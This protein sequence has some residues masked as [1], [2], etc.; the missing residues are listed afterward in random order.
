M[1]RAFHVNAVT[2]APARFKKRPILNALVVAIVVGPFLYYLDTNSERVT[3]RDKKR[4]EK[5]LY[6]R[7]F[8]ETHLKIGDIIEIASTQ[9]THENP[10]IRLKA[11]QEL[12]RAAQVSELG[13]PP[14]INLLKDPDWKIRVSVVESLGRLHTHSDVVLQ[15]LI[16]TLASDSNGSVRFMAA[17]ALGSAGAENATKVVPGL[18]AA[19]DDSD[20]TVKVFS[21][22][23]LERFENNATQAISSLVKLFRHND[24]YVRV[25]AAAAVICI[26]QLPG[27]SITVLSDA[28]T[29]TDANQ[30]VHLMQ[31]LERLGPLAKPA[32]PFIKQRLDH[33]DPRVKSFMQQVIRKIESR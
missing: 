7:F 24:F 6:D 28:L 26:E 16:Q 14:L 2:R 33:D 15:A 27:D 32:L 23:A 22:N 19:L 4:T 18:I 11:A 3:K 5:L 17:S 8:K 9:S 21:A 1:D 12:F 30:L 13:I 31:A 20:N 10:E 29:T 25:A